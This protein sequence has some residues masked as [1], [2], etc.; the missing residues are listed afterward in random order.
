MKKLLLAACAA[1]GVSAASLQAAD[2][3]KMNLK[4][5]HFGPK[6][7]V[8]S[9]VD[10]WWADEIERRSDGQIKI[11]VYWGGS[12]GKATE[13]LKLVGNGVIDFGATPQAYFPNELP[14]IGAPNAVPSVFEQREAAVRVSQEL[15]EQNPHVQAELEA[16]NVHPLFFHALNS[17]YPLCTKPV[18]SMEDFEGL[19]IRSFGAFQP[20][21]WDALGAVGVNVFPPDIYEGLQRGLLDC[22]F[23][24]A[25]LYKATKLYEVATHMADVG[26]GPVTTWPIWV[27]QDKWNNSYPENVKQLIA[28]VSQEAQE[29]SLIALA[30]AE[31]EAFAFLKEKGVE[32]HAFADPEA[33]AAAIPDM[34]DVW[35]ANM[36]DKG[37]EAE[38]QSV[39]AFWRTRMAELENLSH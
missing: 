39:A 26:V 27:N 35:S 13:I 5:A 23:F 31:V 22:G 16:N 19:K 7:F 11:R 38:A 14:L 36:K 34:I 21:M 12:I 30:E 18:T 37:L 4:L 9:E 10:Q 20:P 29:R 2:Y 15:V 25:D 1:I 6:V 32:L 28:E 3:P 33:Y 8:Q 17:F 24:S